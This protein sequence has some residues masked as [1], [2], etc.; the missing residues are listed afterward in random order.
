[1]RSLSRRATSG[2]VLLGAV[3]LTFAAL[4]FAGAIRP[5]SIISNPGTLRQVILKAI[6]VYA[7]HGSLVADTATQGE[8]IYL[9]VGSTAFSIR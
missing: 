1:M 6:S 3:A 7:S 5:P 9:G 8:G 2:A 4:V